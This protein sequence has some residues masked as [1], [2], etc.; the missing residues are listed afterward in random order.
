MTIILF[1]YS[2]SA[3]Q[4]FD[5]IRE[6][7]RHEAATLILQGGQIPMYIDQQVSHEIVQHEEVAFV[8]K[9]FLQTLP[10]EA[11]QRFH[12]FMGV[13]DSFMEMKPW[14]SYQRGD[15]FTSPTSD[16]AILGYNVATY[17][18][19]D[20]GDE[21]Q[22]PQ[23]RRPMRIVG[24]LDRAGSQD[25]GTIFLRADRKPRAGPMRGG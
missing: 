21:L 20:I 9:L 4:Q 12:F 5:L 2:E 17:L 23:F 25:D 6:E 7:I 13:E 16:E 24:I 18:K 1:S 15:W 11:G 3:R 22:I 10:D 19:K 8:S 14:L